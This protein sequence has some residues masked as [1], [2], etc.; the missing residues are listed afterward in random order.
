M[1]SLREQ[2]VHLIVLERLEADG[3]ASFNEVSDARVRLT[4][5]AAEIVRVID[6]ARALCD[7][8]SGDQAANIAADL[9]K[10]I[11]QP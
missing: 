11:G 10:L 8:G 7:A 2:A 9:R 4:N 5:R 1:K 3:L 6:L